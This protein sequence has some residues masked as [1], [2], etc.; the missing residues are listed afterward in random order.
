MERIKL[1]LENMKYWDY[2]KGDA[3]FRKVVKTAVH[4]CL[5]RGLD[6]KPRKVVLT[7]V[8]E[9][10]VEPD[11]VTEANVHFQVS[12]KL[13][14]KL[15]SQRRNRIVLEVRETN[16]SAQL[17]FRRL[18]F[19]AVNTMCQFYQDTPEDAYV[20]VYCHCGAGRG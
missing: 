16:L 1:D 11:G 7:M 12:A 19:R 5:D 2:G 4:D 10:I 9:P 17:F 3:A 8:I 14:S 13:V 20:M 18:G 15:S 6:G